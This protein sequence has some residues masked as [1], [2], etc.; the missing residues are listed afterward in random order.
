MPSKL[1]YKS[2][3]TYG[4][5]MLTG[6]SFF[7]PGDKANHVEVICGCGELFYTRLSSIKRGHTTSCGCKRLNSFLKANTKHGICI[8]ETDNKPRHPI[9][10]SWAGA[11]NRCFSENAESFKRHGGRGITMCNGWANNFG[12]FYKWSIENGWMKGLSIDRINNNG[13]YSCGSC[14]HCVQNG[15]PMNCRWTTLDVQSKNK[16]STVFITAFNETKT[17][18]DWG[19]DDRVKVSIRTVSDRI[20]KGWD[21]EKAMTYRQRL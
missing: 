3:D 7:K 4:E 17:Q 10:N 6:K 2:G 13:H 9:Y 15:W 12:A 19:K 16:S 14:P 11:K 1:E 20:K 21:I 8:G 18:S 5:L